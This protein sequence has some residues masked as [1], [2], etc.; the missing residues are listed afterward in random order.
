[1]RIGI[2]LGGIRIDAIALDLAGATLARQRLDPP[3][4]RPSA[5]LETIAALVNAVE[6]GT[7][8][9]ARIGVG[10]PGSPSPSTGR[11]RDANST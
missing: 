3:R 7:C 1:V 4:G 9:R 6:Q 5:T 2:D 8:A 10:T 11:L